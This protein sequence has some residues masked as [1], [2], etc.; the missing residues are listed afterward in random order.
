[1]QEGVLDNRGGVLMRL[2]MV[3]VLVLL[4][5]GQLWADRT[6]EAVTH[7]NSGNSFFKE[8]KFDSAIRELEEAVRLKPDFAMAYS[9]LGACYVD[10]HQYDLAIRHVEKAIKLEPEDAGYRY[11]LGM[12]YAQKGQYDLAITQLEEALKLNPDLAEARKVLEQLYK[13]EGHGK[14]ESK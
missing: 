11:N 13:I 5:S 2:F 14:K 1:M 10:K 7:F 8:G 12:V 6:E 4:M 9:L 3:V